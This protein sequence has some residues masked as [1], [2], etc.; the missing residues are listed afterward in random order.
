MIKS[1][2]DYLDRHSTT[3]PQKCVFADKERSIGYADFVNSAKRVASVL[4]E[5]EKVVI[6]IDKTVNCLIGMFGAAYA[7]ACYTIIDVQSP[8]ER[9][10]TIL[11]T[12]QS[13]WILTDRKNKSLADKCGFE[14]TIVLEDL[15]NNEINEK[16]LADIKS[17]RIDTDPLYVLFTSGSTGIPKGTVIGHRSVIDYAQVICETFG[18]DEDTV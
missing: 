1:I 18:I 3:N 10:N 12:F 17:R 6:F 9:I 11:S 8:I 4:P 16:K 14:N 2:T 5:K 13:T 7:N 15:L